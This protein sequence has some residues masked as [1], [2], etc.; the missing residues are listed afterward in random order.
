MK[1]KMTIDGDKGLSS[2]AD[3]IG[4]TARL[5]VAVV[6][7]DA[8]A[9]ASCN[10]YSD[11]SA[12]FHEGMLAVATEMVVYGGLVYDA[13]VHA[14]MTAVADSFLKELN[15][16]RKTQAKYSEMHKKALRESKEEQ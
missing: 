1:M 7:V 15:D 10:N 6:T 2:L 11:Q 12:T 8:M 5:G 3:M 16:L 4:D 13:L 9:S 14:G